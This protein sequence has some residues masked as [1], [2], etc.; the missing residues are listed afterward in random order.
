MDF[1]GQHCTIESDDI[2]LVIALLGLMAH[3][4]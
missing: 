4:V 1:L 2:I 3:K